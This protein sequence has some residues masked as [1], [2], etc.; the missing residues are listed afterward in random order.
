MALVT[1][2]AGAHHG[3]MSTPDTPTTGPVP[4]LEELD[5]DQ[6]FALLASHRFGRLALVRDGR[7]EIFPVNCLLTGE[8]IVIRTGEGVKLTHASLAR[9]AFEVDDID[10]ASRQG[11]PVVVKGV[12]EDDTDGADQWSERTIRAAAD[13]WVPGPHEHT[14]AIS[15]PAVSGRRLRREP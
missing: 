2:C 11:W 8:T 10:P 15:H 7:P 14:L 13:P 9:V 12:A 5:H 6:C 3:V 4:T 1:A